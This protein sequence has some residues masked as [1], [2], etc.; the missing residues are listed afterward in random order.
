MTTAPKGEIDGAVLDNGTVLHWPPH[1][2]DRFT[3]VVKRGDRVEAIGIEETTPK[4][5]EHFEVTSLKNLRTD[6]SAENV[7]ARGGPEPPRQRD[8][9]RASTNDDRP[10]RIRDLKRQVERLEREIEQL[11]K[12]L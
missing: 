10:G 11:E 9:A 4:G 7:E 12:D 8:R 1:L 5:D 2:E 6:A 3:T